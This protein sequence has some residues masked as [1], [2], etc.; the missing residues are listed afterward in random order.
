MK[1]IPQL[2]KK[3]LNWLKNTNQTKKTYFNPNLPHQIIKKYSKH[4]NV[5]HF[6]TRNTLYKNLSILVN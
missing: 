5:N 6:I 3:I 4:L 1:L 2:K